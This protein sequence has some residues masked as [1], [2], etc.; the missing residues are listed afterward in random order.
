MVALTI[1]PCYKNGGPHPARRPPPIMA[2]RPPPPP[3]RGDS[4]HPHGAAASELGHLTP[5]D[6]TTSLTARRQPTPVASSATSPRRGGF[7]PHPH[8]GPLPCSGELDHHP[9]P[10]SLSPHHRPLPAEATSS[11][12]LARR[13]QSPPGHG[14]LFKPRIRPL[15]RWRRRSLHPPRPRRHAMHRKKG[16][17]ATLARGRR[18]RG[19]GR[20]RRPYLQMPGAVST[21]RQ[22]ERPRRRSQTREKARERCDPLT[23][24]LPLCVR[25]ASIRVRPVPPRPTDLVEPSHP[26]Y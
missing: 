7:F 26:A 5:H 11:F 24:P 20:G 6:A 12:P 14:D 17:G 13:P 3:R 8:P 1:D 9:T 22:L 25:C 23:P 18:G 15:Q 16:K 2:W 10:V 19:R 21:D 4:P